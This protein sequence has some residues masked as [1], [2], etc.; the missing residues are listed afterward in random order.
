MTVFASPS[1]ARVRPC[2]VLAAE[3]PRVYIYDSGLAEPCW[4]KRRDRRTPVSFKSHV[5]RTVRL[6]N[7]HSVPAHR[8]AWA[9]Y[10]DREIP[11]GMVVHHRCHVGG[12]INPAHLDLCTFG[13]NSQLSDFELRRARALITERS[14]A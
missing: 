14:A 10:H 9:M 11:A 3:K 2:Y 8:W 6:V 5:Y 7:G 12:C 1:M 4:I 13:R